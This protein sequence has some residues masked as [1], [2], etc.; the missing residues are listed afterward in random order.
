MD[1]KTL[2]NQAMTHTGCMSAREM[3]RLA[4][5]SNV[6]V[7]SWLKGETCPTFEQCCELAEMAGLPPVSTAALVRQGSVDGPKHRKMLAKLAKVAACLFLA[8]VTHP[9]HATAASFSH[10]R[11]PNV[12]YVKL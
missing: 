10:S 8:S 3:A 2:V 7:S 12:Y 1:A 11:V 6:T 5:V 9:A 4:N